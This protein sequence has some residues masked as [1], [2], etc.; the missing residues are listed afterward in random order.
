MRH[1]H[2]TALADLFAEQ[3]YDRAVRSEHVAETH[4]DEIG[5]FTVP[6]YRLNYHFADALGRTH[7]VGR[8]DGLV[9][10]YLHER[11]RAV[12]VRHKRAV[13]RTE[14]VVLDRLVRARFH[15]RDMLMRRRV[16][17][18]I[19]LI[20]A[21]HVFDFRLIPHAGD[22]REQIEVG[23]PP[24]KFLFYFVCV[25]LVY[26]EN[27]Q[28]PRSVRRDL[29]AQLAAY[30]S[31]AARNENGLSFDISHDLV[32]IYGNLLTAEQVGYIHLAQRGYRGLSADEL[33]NSGQD[34]H[35]AL[36]LLAYVHDARNLFLSDGRNG[37][38]YFLDVVFRGHP[39]NV[40]RR[41]H[42]AHVG[43]RA[44][45][46]ARIVVHD[47]YRQIFDLV[48]GLHFAH[49]RGAGAAAA[50]Y[51]GADRSRFA[52]TEQNVIHSQQ[53]SFGESRQQHEIEQ[54]DAVRQTG[55][56]INRT[57][58]QRIYHVA[59]TNADYG[60]AYTQSV[61]DTRRAVDDIVQSEYYEKDAGKT[62][63]CDIPPQR[64]QVERHRAFREKHGEQD[65]QRD[66]YEIAQHRDNGIPCSSVFF[67]ISVFRPLTR[68]SRSLPDF[69]VC[70]RQVPLRR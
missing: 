26:I 52:A 49:Q 35:L 53:Q 32:E 31:A 50:Y 63:I 40:R 66:A 18:D 24:F 13:E 17:Y 43:Y 64:Q 69:W 11:L 58:C 47:T 9:R 22:K 39:G 55:L 70:P 33:V 6:A 59:Y 30:G 19:R 67:H 46:L 65:G 23:M 10:G 12:F 36:R 14:H 57:E 20:R 54:Y 60:G 62:Y 61:Y 51:H 4:G 27:D 28:P 3:R 42:Y 68:P 15:E 38:E 37:D 56:H 2:R 34:L 45:D 8:I 48:R 29:A 5:I 16:E 21:E 7:D 41:A 1:G 44:S 25:V